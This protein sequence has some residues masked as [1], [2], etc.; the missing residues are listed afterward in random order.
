MWT[1]QIQ[2][3]TNLHQN[4]VEKVYKALEGRNLIKQMRNVAHPQRKMF[5][6]ATLTPSEDATGGSWFSEG[7]L[8]QALIDIISG[9]IESY[10]SNSS[11]Q[12]D[13]LEDHEEAVPAQKRK[14]PTDGFDEHGNARV[15]I[16]KVV[17]SQNKIKAVKAPTLAKAYK[18]LEPGYKGYPTIRDITRYI[19]DVKVTGSAL[20]QNAIAQLLQVMVYDDRLFKLSRPAQTSEV[21]DDV[22]ANTVTMYRC[23][24][25]PLALMEQRSL[26]KRQMSTD[27]KVRVAA[28]RHEELEALGPGGASEVPCMKCPVFDICGTGG[29][30]NAVSCKYF[31]E[32]YDNLKEADEEVKEKKSKERDKHKVDKGKGKEKEP[33][34]LGEDRGPSIEVE[35][36][37]LEPS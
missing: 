12:E 8:D 16:G 9:V 13:I 7:V 21:K 1:K 27:E 10:V 37:D 2:T 11:W 34:V 28:Y 29:P 30:V 19:A 6:S 23:F 24:K 25:T 35:M 33:L 20:P 14:R 22:E 18:P 4:T 36:E 3:K 5:I 31:T 32:W 26:A 17:D 15:K